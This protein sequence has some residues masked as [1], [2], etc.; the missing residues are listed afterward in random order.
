MAVDASDVSVGVVTGFAA[1]S[2]YPASSTA[3][4]PQSVTEF[5]TPEK[6]FAAVNDDMVNVAFYDQSSAASYMTGRE[7][8]GPKVDDY[9]NGVSFMCHPGKGDVVEILNL[10]LAAAVQDASFTDLCNKAAYAQIP[11]ISANMPWTENKLDVRA[12]IVIMTEADYAPFSSYADDTGLIGFDVELVSLICAAAEVKFTEHVQAP[13]VHVVLKPIHR[14]EDRHCAFHRE[15][16]DEHGE[17]RV[18]RECG[19]CGRLCCR[20]GLPCLV[21]ALLSSVSH[22]VRDSFGIVRSSER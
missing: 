18:R 3:F 2:D 6:L 4:S 13:P 14:P 1:G 16:R 15:V 7:F 21:N 9:A 22:G 10:G 8:I 5:P 19:R 20:F 17:R 11:C 12:D